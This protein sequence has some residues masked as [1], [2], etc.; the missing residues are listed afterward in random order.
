MGGVASAPR[1][2]FCGMTRLIDAQRAV[3]AGAWA[4]GLILWPGSKRAADPAEAER[5]SR[6]LRRQVE[7]AG[8]FVNQPLDEVA[9]MVDTIGLSMVQLHGDEGPAYADEV[10]RRTGA[11]VIKAMPVVSGEDVQ[12]LETFRRVDFHLL[13][14]HHPDLRGGTGQ[15]FEWDLAA[16]RR[17]KVPLILSGGLTPENVGAAIARVHPYAV[18]VAS[19]TEAS[20]GIKD[21]H[22]LEAFA[23]A[24]R[25]T[26]EAN[27]A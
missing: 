24:V 3:E 20:P 17:S 18:D 7:V 26:A 22:K 6:L 16:R 12:A 27:V 10:A 21:P 11:K 2:K 25:A 13:D 23:A 1:I 8:V 9:A 15:T 5:I 4:I 14:A 19:G